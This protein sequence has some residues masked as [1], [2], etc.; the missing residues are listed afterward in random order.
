[1]NIID[2]IQSRYEDFTEAE[3]NIAIYILNNPKEFARLDVSFIVNTIKVSK[4]TLV[5]FAKKLG[6]NGYNEFRYALSS[7]LTS[8]LYDNQS[9]SDSLLSI[10]CHQYSQ[11][12]LNIENCISDDLMQQLATILFLSSRIY[13][14]GAHRTY[15]PISHLANRAIRIGM[16]INETYLS[17][18]FLGRIDASKDQNDIF[19]IFSV[20]NNSNMVPLF[21]NKIK[22]SNRKSILVTMTDLPHN[23]LA[24]LCIKL[25]SPGAKYGQFIDEQAIFMVFV[26][27]IVAY[28]AKK[29]SSLKK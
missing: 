17:D 20:K 21:L 11:T 25:P 3:K 12:I 27:L 23:H 8:A 1:M 5:R 16:D 9:N 18:V 19:L 15:T 24:S 22:E 7:Y 13:A 14:F 26:E 29:K 6:F 10:V 28:V 2:L 4:P